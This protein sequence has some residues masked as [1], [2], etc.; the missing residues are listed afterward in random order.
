MFKTLVPLTFHGLTIFTGPLH[1]KLYNAPPQSS[2]NI[3]PYLRLPARPALSSVTRRR[4]SKK[5]FNLFKYFFIF[6]VHVVLRYLRLGFDRVMEMFCHANFLF[7]NL[8]SAEQ[9]SEILENEEEEKFLL[10]KF[11]FRWTVVTQ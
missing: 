10:L 6:F 4:R 5:L 7:R 9:E 1:K 8:Q 2:C 11:F 3:I